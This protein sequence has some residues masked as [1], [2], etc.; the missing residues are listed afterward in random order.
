MAS[1]NARWARAPR[2]CEERSRKLRTRPE[3]SS[4]RS[5]MV[6]CARRCLRRS[7]ARN[8]D[9][10]AARRELPARPAACASAC[11]GSKRAPQRSDCAHIARRRRLPRA[12]VGC[13]RARAALA[14]RGARA[15][16]SPN[17]PSR[18][19]SPRASARGRCCGAARCAAPAPTGVETPS[20]L[21][22]ALP[23]SR[24]ISALSTWCAYLPASACSAAF[25]SRV[26]PAV[27]GSASSCSAATLARPVER[28][29]AAS[30]P[31]RASPRSL[32]SFAAVLAISL[33]PPLPVVAAA[34]AGE[35]A[36]EGV[37]SWPRG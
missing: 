19:P 15:R 20:R 30:E 4:R 16:R 17:T 12:P 9:D 6:N 18:R 1:A 37:L 26:R 25:C 5:E 33:S 28:R 2:R 32:L 24:R 13:G 27:E 3:M 21:Q 31:R 11:E 35:A 10:S 29:R 14:V 22:P 7:R 8:G 23:S 34:L 36:A